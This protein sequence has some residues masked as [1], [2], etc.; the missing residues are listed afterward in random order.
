MALE[1]FKPFIIAQLIKREI[2]HNVRSA[3]RYIEAG[4][5]RSG[6][7]WKKRLKAPSFS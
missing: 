5:T 2:V 3:S 1:L 4:M 7:S 6:I